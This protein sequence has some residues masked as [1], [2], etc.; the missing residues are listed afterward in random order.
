MKIP[1]KSV[2]AHKGMLSKNPQ[3]FTASIMTLGNT[4]F[5]AVPMP[6]VFIIV[7]VIPCI[8][9]NTE[10]IKFMPYTTNPLAIANLIKYFKAASGLLIS[11][12]LAH[13]LAT[14]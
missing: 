4:V 10:S 8:I 1:P 11:V 13:D 5:V 2:T 14:P 12:R 3:S 6:A 9:S 7:W